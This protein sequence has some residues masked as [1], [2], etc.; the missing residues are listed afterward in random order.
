M[1]SK[2]ESVEAELESVPAESNRS[3]AGSGE[4][5]AY[6][7]HDD[8]PLL[9]LAL[10]S[11][12]HVASSGLAEERGKRRSE[13]GGGAGGRPSTSPADPADRPPSPS[14]PPL[15]RRPTSFPSSPSSPADFGH[16]QARW[17]ELLRRRWSSCARPKIRRP[18][19]APPPVRCCHSSRVVAGAGEG[20]IFFFNYRLRLRP[21]LEICFF[22]RGVGISCA[23]CKSPMLLI[24]CT[25]LLESASR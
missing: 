9:F 4:P 1:M 15:Q 13:G 20:L 22:L 3:P 6:V 24:F 23:G 11:S 8:D 7:P 16:G 19:D 17:V 21:L 12:M 2:L 25:S 10:R 5:S 14:L 18:G